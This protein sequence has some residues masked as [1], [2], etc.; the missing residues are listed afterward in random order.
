MS[1][2]EFEIFWSLYNASNTA[3]LELDWLIGFGE[4]S[5]IF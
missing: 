4:N 1:M 5:I 2:S 3:S